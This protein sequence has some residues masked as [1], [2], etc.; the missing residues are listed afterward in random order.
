MLLLCFCL[1]FTGCTAAKMREYYAKEE[2]YVNASGIVTHI[3]Y[4]E[5]KSAL[6]LAFSDLSPEFSDNSFKIVGDNLPI[7]QEMG[8]DEKIKIGDSVDFITAGRYFGDGYV[9][10]IVG[11]S[12]A[13]ETLL[14]FE[15]GVANLLAWL[16]SSG[17]G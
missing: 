1:L 15:D 6:Y 14:T 11:I 13:G 12:A 16:G 10:P 8:I 7:V 2:N 4:N 5:D 9:M 17:N 3:S